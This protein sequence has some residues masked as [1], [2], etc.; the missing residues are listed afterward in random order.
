VWHDL[1]AKPG[2]TGSRRGEHELAEHEL[3]EHELD[4]PV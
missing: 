3:A 1:G 2:S 4:R